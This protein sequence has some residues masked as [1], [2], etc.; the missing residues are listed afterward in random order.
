MF[1]IVSSHGR[2]Q[3]QR[4]LSKKKSV[5]MTPEEIESGAFCFATP[6]FLKRALLVSI[7]YN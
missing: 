7:R 6:A 4:V 2:M 1:I 3:G 5:K